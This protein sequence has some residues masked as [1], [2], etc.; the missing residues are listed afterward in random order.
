[1]SG[2]VDCDKYVDRGPELGGCNKKVGGVPGQMDNAGRVPG[3]AEGNAYIAGV[4]VGRSV[5]VVNAPFASHSNAHVVTAPVRTRI[6]V[7]PRGA[8]VLARSSEYVGE[9][10]FGCVATGTR[11]AY[12]AVRIGG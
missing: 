6:G 1:M 11:A 10:S 9:Y 5:Y 2:L 12:W 3:V 7:H 8:A 4:R